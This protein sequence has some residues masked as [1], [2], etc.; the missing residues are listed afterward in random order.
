MDQNIKQAK[1]S[2]VSFED[3]SLDLFPIKSLTTH[4]RVLAALQRAI[5]SGK[6]QPGE[7]LIEGELAEKLKVSRGSVRPALREL[8]FQ[9]LV[10]IV[11]FKGA[12]VKELNLNDV[13]ELYIFRAC[14][15][16]FAIDLID[17]RATANDYQQLDQIC[18]ELS[19][20]CEKN[21][22]M[23]IV[24]FDLLFHKTLISA[25]HHRWLEQVTESLYPQTKMFIVA[26]K[27][28]FSTHQNLQE[29]SKEHRSIL[30]SLLMH[31]TSTAK[32]AINEH[33]KKS[34]ERLLSDIGT[35]DQNEFLQ[36]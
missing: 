29:I 1:I 12:S 32:K 18:K 27:I 14:L 23:K 13:R 9:G 6:F 36:T 34:G 19:K 21:Q 15:E 16:E 8:S 24:E 20:A 26:S 4:D 35:S 25:A 17:E 3:K 5:L 28:S 11:P 2:L 33:I 7:R 10:E 22:I 30:D 31:D